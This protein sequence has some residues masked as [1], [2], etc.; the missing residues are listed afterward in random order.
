MYTDWFSTHSDLGEIHHHDTY[1][2]ERGDLVIYDWYGT[3]AE[4]HIEIVTEY[5]SSTGTMTSLGGNTGNARVPL[6]GRWCDYSLVAKHTFTLNASVIWG[7]IH[8]FY[9]QFTADKTEAEG[10]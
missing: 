7:Y 8:P 6:G 9:E 5:D 4:D 2:P 1:I 10:N 3:G